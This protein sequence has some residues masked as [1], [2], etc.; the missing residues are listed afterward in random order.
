M[1]LEH[2]ARLFTRCVQCS[3]ESVDGGLG[4]QNVEHDTQ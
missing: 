3:P 1:E 4:F 2:V